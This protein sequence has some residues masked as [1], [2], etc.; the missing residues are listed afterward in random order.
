MIF[1]EYGKV[2][3]A[4]VASILLLVLLFVRLDFLGALGAV[5]GIDNDISHSQGQAAFEQVI[6]REKPTADFTNAE[7]RLCVNQAFQP[8]RGVVFADAEGNSNTTLNADGEPAVHVVV[9]S[10]VYSDSNGNP[11]ELINYYNSTDD[12][13]VLNAGHYSDGHDKCSLADFTEDS[14]GRLIIPSG[15]A[16]NLPGA[17]TVTYKATDLENQ[18]GLIR[19]MFLVDNQTLS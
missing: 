9:T 11:T 3:V 6:E 15:T 5:V 16:Q 2:A 14:E 1:G 10:I 8:L 4:V 12:V 17:I 19:M 18:V 13:I 7:K